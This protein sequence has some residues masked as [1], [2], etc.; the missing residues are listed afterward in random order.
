MV[1]LVTAMNAEKN[2]FSFKA[3]LYDN[4]SAN[5]GTC[6][7]LMPW[8][9]CRRSERICRR[10]GK[11]LRPGRQIAS[12]DS[13]AS[14]S[15]A[16]NTLEALCVRTQMARI[17]GGSVAMALATSVCHAMM[18]YRQYGGAPFSRHAHM[19]CARLNFYLRNLRT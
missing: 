17:I 2:V 13:L 3:Y 4:A 14:T 16:C 7:L 8:P 9:D 6:C 5:Y 15:I 19:L 18:Q 12:R 11:N 10:Q 1:I